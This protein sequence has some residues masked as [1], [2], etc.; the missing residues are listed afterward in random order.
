[1]D[2][3]EQ[4]HLVS[5]A[6]ALIGSHGAAFTHM[7]LAREQ[8]FFVFFLFCESRGYALIGSHG[9]PCT[10]LFVGREQVLQV[11]LDALW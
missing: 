7:L 6:S 11:L 3:K 1:M 9:A 5:R 2:L 10:H 8:V 4:F